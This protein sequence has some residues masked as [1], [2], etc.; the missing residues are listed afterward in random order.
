MGEAGKA[1]AEFTA[2]KD[3]M[4]ISEFLETVIKINILHA[5]PKSSID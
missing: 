1:L 3:V 5:T 2:Q 4:N